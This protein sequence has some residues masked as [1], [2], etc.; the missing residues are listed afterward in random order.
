MNS[1]VSK[2]IFL[3]G[4]LYFCGMAIAHFFS[5]KW[6]ILF[7]YYDTPY[8]VYQDKIISFALCAYI[9]LFIG[10]SKNHAI[11]LYAIVVMGITTLGLTHV[12]LSHA[13]TSILNKEHSTLPYWLQTIALTSYTIV[14]SLLYFSDKKEK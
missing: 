6:P 1:K 7:V 4:A 10:A 13:L 3:A 9:A 5:L 14:L 11:A 2:Y 8:Y 12:N